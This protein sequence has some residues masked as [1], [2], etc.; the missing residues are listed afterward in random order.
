MEGNHFNIY[1][2]S[3]SEKP[4]KGKAE[5]DVD[6]NLFGEALAEALIEEE[7]AERV[8]L[9]AE[10]KQIT[11]QDAHRPPIVDVEKPLS[12]GQIEELFDIVNGEF[13]RIGLRR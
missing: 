3:G 5:F 1:R 9:G 8:D 13:E 11:D 6:P 10:V 2:Y 12:D 7:T 4:Q